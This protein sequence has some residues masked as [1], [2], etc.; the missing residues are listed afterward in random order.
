MHLIELGIKVFIPASMMTVLS[1]FIDYGVHNYI[2]V[3][4]ITIVIVVSHHFKII[5][6]NLER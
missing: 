5:I 3:L 2:A 6:V 1:T 4:I